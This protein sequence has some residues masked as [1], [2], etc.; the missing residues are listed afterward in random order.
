MTKR[1]LLKERN[2]EWLLHFTRAENLPN[3]LKF[4]L[5]PRCDL[6]TKS[7]DVQVNDQYRYDGCEDAICLSVEFPNY[8]MFYRLRQEDTRVKWVVLLLDANLI[9]DSEC[10]FCHD[11]AGSAKVYNIPLNERMGVRAFEKMFNELSDGPTR[12]KLG[13]ESWYPTSPQA[14]IL[15]FEKVPI[16]Y[17][18]SIFFYNNDT[19]NEYIELIPQGIK[20][21]VDRGLFSYRKDWEY[22]R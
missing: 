19:L 13:I 11:N 14:E 16:S 20:A 12:E 18:H 6:E 7:I 3:I 21:K 8:K 17:F 9:C 2:I 22:W 5:L 15:V 1:K 4:G 10:A